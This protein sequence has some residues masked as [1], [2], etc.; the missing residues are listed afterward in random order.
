MTDRFLFS[1]VI[2]TYNRATLI[3]QAIASVREQTYPHWEIIVVDDGSTDNTESVVRAF[4][5]RRITYVKQENKE[6]GAARNAGVAHSIGDIVT[7]LDS[8]DSFLP[9]HLSVAAEAFSEHP[10]FSV[11]CTSYEIRGERKTRKVIHY[12]K[13]NAHLITANPLSCHGVFL[14]RE[15]LMQ[16]RFHEERE[17]AGVEDWELWLRI[18]SRHAIHSTP[19]ITCWMREHDKRSVINTTPE[20]LEARF[21]LFIRL[22]NEDRE[23]MDMMNYDDFGFRASCYSY[24]A[25]HLALTKNYRRR[26]IYWLMRACVESPSM[27]FTRRFAA[28][29]K[30]LV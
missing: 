5:D 4:A 2:P 22:V 26:A 3:G 19:R 14:R 24:M 13:M 10:D 23:I 18:A 27:I 15:V 7:F 6:R 29:L 8:D 1:V 25:L 9:E 16:D 17:L 28:I 11:F 21:R 30:H 20:Q 12:G